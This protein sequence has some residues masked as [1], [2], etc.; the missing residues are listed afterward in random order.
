MAKLAEYLSSH[1][2]D[3][4]CLKREERRKIS[5]ELIESGEFDRKS[6]HDLEDMLRIKTI[7]NDFPERLG[8]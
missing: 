6:L 8:V 1:C 5:E 4:K 2:K 7:D 3:F